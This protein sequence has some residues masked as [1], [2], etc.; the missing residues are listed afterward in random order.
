MFPS[1]RGYRCQMGCEE[2]REQSLSCVSLVA[3]LSLKMGSG[4]GEKLKMSKK[5]WVMG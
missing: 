5:G 2:K 4:K 1:G 3:A